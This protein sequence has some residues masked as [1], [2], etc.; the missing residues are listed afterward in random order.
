MRC[1]TLPRRISV[2]CTWMKD[3]RL[4]SVLS[5]T[6]VR[7]ALSNIDCRSTTSRPRGNQPLTIPEDELSEMYVDRGMTITEIAEKFDC[8]NATISNKLR[9]FGIEAK[10]PNHGRAIQI[11]ED[12][13]RE[14]YV[15]EEWTT[16]ELGEHYDCDPT[17]I[18]R[19]LRWYGIE[20][21]HTLPG[22][23]DYD[24]PYGENWNDQRWKALEVAEFRCEVCGISDEEHRQ[25]FVDRTRKVGIGLDVHHTVRAGL[26][27]QWDE[28]SIED[29]NA[30]RNLEVLCQ[31]CHM[32][33]GDR[34]GTY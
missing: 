25:K 4:P 12:E 21:R 20:E 31:E 26:F 30:V 24:E 34:V 11:P 13:L 16:Y 1:T 9:E 3:S 17:V 19:R 2:G 8:H 7:R 29:A 6:I 15:E 33:Y 32:E 22:D 14:L 5:S 23:G 28:A 10:G 27:R 18:E